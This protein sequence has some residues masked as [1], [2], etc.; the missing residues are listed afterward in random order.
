MGDRVGR[1]ARTMR[2]GRS[3]VERYRIAHSRVEHAPR[4][5][6]LDA[7]IRDQACQLG[8]GRATEEVSVSP[9]LKQVSRQI[10]APAIG[11]GEHTVV[12]PGVPKGRPTQAPHVRL[13]VVS[14]SGGV[15]RSTTDTMQLGAT[16]LDFQFWFRDPAAG[17]SQFNLSNGLHVP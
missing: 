1:P 14:A 15:A 12:V 9:G 10:I 8:C 2:I 13:D 6:C 11:P 4:D 17:G 7:C 3:F 5:G 16:P